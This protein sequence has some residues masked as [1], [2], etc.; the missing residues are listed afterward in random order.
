V[1][2]H[3]ARLREPPPAARFPRGGKIHNSLGEAPDIS[4]HTCRWARAVQ[5]L[6]PG[7]N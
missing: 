3:A 5:A 4:Y 1:P 2:P 6:R 7:Q